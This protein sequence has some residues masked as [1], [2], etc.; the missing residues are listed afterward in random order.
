M[1]LALPGGIIV[2][3]LSVIIYYVRSVSPFRGGIVTIVFFGALILLAVASIIS[4]YYLVRAYFG[5]EIGYIFTTKEIND[6]QKE[7]TDY[8]QST[9]SE[10]IDDMVLNDLSEEL[11]S[12]YSKYTAANINSN[13]RKSG[14]LHKS[15]VMLICSLILLFIT[16]FPFYIIY[17]E[18]NYVK[19]RNTQENTKDISI[20]GKDKPKPIPPPQKPTPAGGRFVKE[21]EVPEKKSQK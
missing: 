18:D 14:F 10:S 1:S 6:Y 20:M 4:I 7:L 8:Y 12:Q 11:L 15:L 5:Y 9:S 19:V 13:E 3:I 21:G 17:V 16:S 2:L